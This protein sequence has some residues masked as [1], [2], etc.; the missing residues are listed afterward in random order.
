M[1]DQLKIVARQSLVHNIQAL[2]IPTPSAGADF[3]VF[4][5]AGEDWRILGVRA[6]LVTS[7]AVAN[8]IPSFNWDDTTNVARQVPPGVVQVASLSIT[9][10]WNLDSS[11]TSTS[12]LG[13]VAGV[14]L[15]DVVVPSGWRFRSSTQALDVADQW[16]NIFVMFERMDEPPYRN[17]L[18]GTA[19]DAAV[20]AELNRE[21][22][23][24]Q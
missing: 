4:P 15:P 16:Q 11:F 24:G 17:P 20:Q 1:D 10:C 5:R 12:I 6:Q 9:W 23:G 18:V 19:L 13:T 14:S 8:R 22:N 7:A 3:I 21:M 2:P